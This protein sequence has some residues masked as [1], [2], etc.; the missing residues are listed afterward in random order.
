MH[1]QSAVSTAARAHRGRAESILIRRSEAARLAGWS[2]VTLARRERT[3]PSIPARV[4]IGPGA[5]GP[6]AYRRDEW[7][8]Y[9]D[10]LPRVAPPRPATPEAT[11]QARAL[12]RRSVEKRQARAGSTDRR[13]VD[14][15][16]TDEA[17][18][19]NAPTGSPLDA[20]SASAGQESEAGA[21]A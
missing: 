19:E 16:A 13:G 9:V 1:E 20:R 14:S 5:N 2:I 17:Q 21:A 3:D 18:A 10:Q 15:R 11:A 6:F 8:A 4:N 12:A 7:Q